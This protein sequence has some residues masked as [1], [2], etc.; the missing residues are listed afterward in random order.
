M[1]AGRSGQGSCIILGRRG[2][3]A[4]GPGLCRFA[5]AGAAYDCETVRDYT[6]RTPKF[7]NP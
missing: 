2:F 5:A 1:A 6:F 4:A 3:R 7:D